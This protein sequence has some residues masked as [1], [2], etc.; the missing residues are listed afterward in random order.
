MGERQSLIESGK[1]YF[2]WGGDFNTDGSAV[3][4]VIDQLATVLPLG[5]TGL[6]TWISVKV[7]VGR[8]WAP[9]SVSDL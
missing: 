4:S 2:G 6:V 1:S 3:L 7:K 5:T 9:P 8:E